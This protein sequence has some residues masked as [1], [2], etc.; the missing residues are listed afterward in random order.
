MISL[1]VNFTTKGLRRKD[2]DLFFFITKEISSTSGKVLQYFGQST[3]VLRGKYS[4]TKAYNSSRS[5][6]LRSI[7]LAANLSAA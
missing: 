1:L 2:T 6:P 3:P 4:E 7:I 5:F